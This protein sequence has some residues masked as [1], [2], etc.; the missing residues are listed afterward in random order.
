MAPTT[1]CNDSSLWS[2][3]ALDLG[4]EDLE[5]LGGISPMSVYD[6]KLKDV[7]YG[8]VVIVIVYRGCVDIEKGGALSL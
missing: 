5:G 6:R 3:K 4:L 7:S 8:D 2:S 1:A